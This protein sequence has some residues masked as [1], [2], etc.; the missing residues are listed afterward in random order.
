MLGPDSGALPARVRPLLAADAFGLLDDEA[1]TAF[2]PALARVEAH[3]GP[4]ERRVA[5]AGGF[6]PLYHAFRSIQGYEAWIVDGPLI[7]RFH[8][9]LGPGVLDRFDYARTVTQAQ[10]QDAEEVRRSFR[11]ALRDLVGD[12]GVLVLPT[13]PDVA[14]LLIDSD[15]ALNDYRMRALNLLCLSVLSGLPQVSM[16]LATRLGAPLGLSL[17]G[18]PGSDLGLVRLAVEI[19][20]GGRIPT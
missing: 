17:L 14:P 20:A 7:E 16:P 13:M 11:A 19:A 15:E 18:P 1:S 9:P 2:A 12:D 4:A 5:A 10:R 6:E 3:L 8:P